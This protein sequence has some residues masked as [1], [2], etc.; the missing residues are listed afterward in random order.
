MRGSLYVCELETVPG[1]GK[2]AKWIYQR[3]RR[4]QAGWPLYHDSSRAVSAG[5]YLQRGALLE[6]QQR[7]SRF[8]DDFPSATLVQKITRRSPLKI[9]VLPIKHPPHSC[10]PRPGLT[11]CSSKNVGDTLSGKYSSFGLRSAL[12]TPATQE[13]RKLFLKKQRSQKDRKTFARWRG[14]ETFGEKKNP[15]GGEAAAADLLHK[16]FSGVLRDLPC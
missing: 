9:Q 11:N 2:Q 1:G 3:P 12:R 15:L 8:R 14:S 6:K 7:V 10:V 4:L 13:T 5:V 16:H